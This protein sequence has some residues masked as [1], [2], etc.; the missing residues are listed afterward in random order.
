MY[1][2]KSFFNRRHWTQLLFAAAIILAATFIY[3]ENASTGKQLD[4][5]RAGDAMPAIEL[6]EL[7][8]ESTVLQ[9]AD[10][11][12]MLINLWASWCKPCINELPLLNEAQAFAPDVDFV[13]INMKEGLERIEPMIE[14][15]DLTMHILRDEQLAWKQALGI[16]GYPATVLVDGEGTI[17][18]IHYGAYTSIEEILQHTAIVAPGAGN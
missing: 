17:Q 3:V 13:A 4:I 7:T 9:P 10:G 1:E 15:Y 11:S 12:P 14:R 6:L 18:H 16:K 5:V 2:R 8:G